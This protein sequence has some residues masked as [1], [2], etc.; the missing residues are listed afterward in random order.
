MFAG[1][2]TKFL[3]K[4]WSVA[5]DF[6]GNTLRLM[7][8]GDAVAKFGGSAWSAISK[9][10]GFGG[11]LLNLVDSINPSHRRDEARRLAGR[12]GDEIARKLCVE[13]GE[14]RIILPQKLVPMNEQ[15]LKLNRELLRPTEIA[16]RLG[17]T[18]SYIYYVLREERRGP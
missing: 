18:E 1:Q 11:S 14:T 10:A 9:V 7:Y 8:A 13:F 6:Q 12:V 2:G 3:G 5:T 15:I 4:A 16:Q 17:C